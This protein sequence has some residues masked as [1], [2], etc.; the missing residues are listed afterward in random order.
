MDISKSGV[1]PEKYQNRSRGK[2][3]SRV[4]Q[5]VL[6]I[7]SKD[8]P[9]QT[10]GDTL[11]AMSPDFIKEFESTV[12]N[13]KDKYKSPFY[14]FVLTK[15]EFYADNVVRNF[16]I[17]RQTCPYAVEMMSEYPNH[18][19]T[20]YIVDSEKGRV[21]LAWSLPPWGD[22]MTIAKNPQLYD[23][24][25]VKW[26]EQCLTGALNRDSYSFDYLAS[27]AI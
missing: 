25:L 1:I 3:S 19:K 16:F 24:Q 11:E 4:G 12:E 7:I 18:V 6:D 22:C 2:T 10:V 8:Q 9:T 27:Q 26:V 17:A 5:A 20:L 23:P 13:N 14:I 21:S 15:K